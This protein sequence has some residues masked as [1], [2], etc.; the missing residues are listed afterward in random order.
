VNLRRVRDFFFEEW[1]PV[2]TLRV[3]AYVLLVV[4]VGLLAVAGYQQYRGVTRQPTLIGS[5][6]HTS[7]VVSGDTIHRASHPEAFRGAMEVHW[8]YAL[9]T[10]LGGVILLSIIRGQDRADPFAPDSDSEE[11][12]DK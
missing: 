11:D 1:D 7:F 6:M 5:G 10:F 4:G 9:A 2:D 12:R 3:L 8:Y